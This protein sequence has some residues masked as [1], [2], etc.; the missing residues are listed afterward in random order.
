[1]IWFFHYLSIAIY[2][3]HQFHNPTKSTMPYSRMFNPYLMS[4]TINE[5]YS[6]CIYHTW[7]CLAYICSKEYFITKKCIITHSHFISFSN[8]KFI[9]LKMKAFNKS[10]SFS[11]NSSQFFTLFFFFTLSLTAIILVSCWNHSPNISPF[12]VSW[13]WKSEQNT[14]S[15]SPYGSHV[16][17]KPLFSFNYYSALSLII[18]LIL[19]YSCWFF[20]FFIGWWKV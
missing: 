13:Q 3:I 6:N 7:E 8:T 20:L 9:T 1:M 4:V 5:W 16:S 17:N 14:S 2:T 12:F 19:F 15:F 11:T 18:F 10:S